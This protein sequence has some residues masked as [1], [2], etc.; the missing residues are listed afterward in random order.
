MDASNVE[1]RRGKAGRYRAF[2]FENNRLLPL[3]PVQ[4]F[5]TEEEAR[6][7]LALT[8]IALLPTARALLTL[9]ALLPTARALLTPDEI[10][11]G[12]GGI[13]AEEAARRRSLVKVEP[14]PWW[15]FW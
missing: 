6:H 1:Y 4:G 7:H 15:K 3:S 10:W 9:I 12:V 14:K 13:L 2:L 5:G 8:L 11:Q